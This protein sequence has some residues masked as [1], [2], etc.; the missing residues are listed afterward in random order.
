M[1]SKV[2]YS[3]L[4]KS[5]IDILNTVRANASLEYQNAVP[6][7]TPE[8]RVSQVG[9]AICGYPAIANQFISAL[10]NRIAAVVV[11]AALFN[12]PYKDLKK[13]FLEYGETVE[14]VF[15]EIAKVREFSAEKAAQRELKRTLPV[16]K[17]A[18][19][20]INWQVQYPVTVQMQDLQRAFLSLDGVQDLIAKIVDS[21]Y[22]AAEYDEYLLFK[23]VIIKGVAAGKMLPI[24]VNAGDTK[25]AAVAFRAT[26]N[27][28]TFMST[29]YNAFGVHNVS[30]RED[31]YIFMDSEY[32]AR[33]DVEVL[34]GAFNMD[35]TTFLG[36]LRL[37]DS[38]T[39]FDNVRWDELR[40]AG[41]MVEEVTQQELALM[42]GVHAVAVDR[43]WFQFYDNLSQFTETYVSSGL[44]WNYNYNVW[45][46]V[47]TSPFSNAVVFAEQ[48]T[49]P[50]V[51]EQITAKVTQVQR[52]EN[53]TAVILEPVVNNPSLLGNY[54]FVQDQA[55]T[56][57]GIAVQPYGAI[58]FA[59]GKPSFRFRMAY[60]DIEY[61]QT[62][63]LD[64][65]TVAVGQV[66]TYQKMN[67]WKAAQASEPPAKAKTK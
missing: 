32:N 50:Q 6:E 34:A 33:F 64:P 42:R 10:V 16:V 52:D 9:Q 63:D 20:P 28:M 35:K 58:V 11:K 27:A 62:D 25:N 41:N 18:F 19:H 36:H 44:Y 56:N 31:Q 39:E 48:G 15:V 38:F 8:M 51:P 2:A 26:S 61:Y 4:N 23:Y 24:A 37:I 12:N 47:S 54:S 17:A 5:T 53:G 45:K 1:P 46:I 29:K 49:I 43:E 66:F 21:V 65:S 30:P 55:A 60:K 22:R 57:A 67:G 40:E 59:P 7:M 14:E 3:S 13:G